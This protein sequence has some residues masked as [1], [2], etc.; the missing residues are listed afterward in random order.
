MIVITRLNG[1]RFGLNPDLI[2]RIHETP[3]TTLFMIDGDK[4]I[5]TE[6]MLHV[7]ELITVYRASVVALARTMPMAG[8]HPTL[9]LVPDADGPPGFEGSPPVAITRAD[10]GVMT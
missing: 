6:S 1:I 3:D 10:R 5:V 7:I 8:P 9:E 2:E 4:Y